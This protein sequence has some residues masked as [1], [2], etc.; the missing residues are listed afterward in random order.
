MTRKLFECF[1]SQLS[2]EGMIAREGNYRGRELLVDARNTREQN[3]QIKAGERPEGFEA[4]TAKGRQKDCDASLDEENTEKHYGYKNHAKVD[5]KSKLVV[6]YK[7]TAANV[8]IRRCSR[9]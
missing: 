5:A 3:A 9:I 2:G 8:H 4:D 6:S 7:S 1:A